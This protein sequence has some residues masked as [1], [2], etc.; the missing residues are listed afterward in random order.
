MKAGIIDSAN[1]ADFW[2]KTIGEEFEYTIA[3]DVNGL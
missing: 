1:K 3:S 2:E